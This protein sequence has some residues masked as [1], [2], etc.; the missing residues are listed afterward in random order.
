MFF[1][2]SLAQVKIFVGASQSFAA[3]DLNVRVFRDGKITTMFK[4]PPSAR[5][6]KEISTR[7][8][9]RLLTMFQSLYCDEMLGNKELME[10]IRH[11]DL[12]VGELL[13]LCSSLVADK[14]SLPHVVITAATIS[15][16]T[17]FAFGLP[18]PPSYVPQWSVQLSDEP[19]F[20]ERVNSVF[21]WMSMYWFYINEFCPKF[22]EIKTK[23]NITPNKNIQ[24]TLGRVDLIIG[25]MPFMLEHP[26]PLLPSKNFSCIKFS[27]L[28]IRLTVQFQGLSSRGD[29][30]AHPS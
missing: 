19:T 29:N 11:A 30:I 17:A 20:L 25:Q 27:L 1:F 10:E 9:L 13:Y 3:N 24:E 15:T 8:E 5:E 26:R 22:D 18:S 14:F 7:Q 6:M 16:P 12:V 4:K 23:F 2:F 21:H 28:P